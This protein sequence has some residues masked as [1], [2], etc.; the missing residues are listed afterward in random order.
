MTERMLTILRRNSKKIGCI[1]DGNIFHKIEN[2]KIH[3]L[4]EQIKSIGSIRTA[5]IFFDKK[6]S[7]EV[8][9][10]FLD[11]GLSPV[12]VPSDLDVYMA[13]EALDCLYFKEN[14]ILTFGIVDDRLLPVVI[15][16]REKIEVLI[17]APNEEV[18]KCYL[19]YSDYV[20]YLNPT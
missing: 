18:A 17:V 3:D 6:L 10:Q 11:L 8:H 2:T 14:D 19:P 20:V 1:F 13:I 4:L 7:Q 12:I 16:T 5:K 15:T 9:N